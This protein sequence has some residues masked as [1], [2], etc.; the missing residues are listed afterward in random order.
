MKGNGRHNWK[1]R[2]DRVLSLFSSRRNWGSPIPSPECVPPLWFRG[3]GPT[4]LR[5]R[6]WGSPSSDEGTDW[7]EGC[8]KCKTKAGITDNSATPPLNDHG[9][10]GRVLLHLVLLVPGGHNN[11]STATSRPRTIRLWIIRPWT[12][13][14]WTIR[15]WTIRP[16]INHFLLSPFL[17]HLQCLC[18]MLCSDPV[19]SQFYCIIL[20]SQPSFYSDISFGKRRIYPA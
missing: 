2:V 3:G 20:S 19:F 7:K 4:R 8:Y 1:H 16:W 14:P 6:G 10:V 12:I 5:E 11:I 15:P 17:F 18:T 13:R 9:A